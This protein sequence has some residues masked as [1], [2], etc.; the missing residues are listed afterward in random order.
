MKKFEIKLQIQGNCN[1]NRISALQEEGEDLRLP[2]VPSSEVGVSMADE[3]R[4]AGDEIKSFDSMAAPEK[5][6]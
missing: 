2:L 3:E 1:P 5:R 6:Q 4:S